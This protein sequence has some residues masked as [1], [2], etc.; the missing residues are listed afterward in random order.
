[1][2]HA[3]SSAR[4]AEAAFRADLRKFPDSGW[5]LSGLQASLERQGTSAEAAMVKA[6]FEAAWRDADTPLTAAR[7]SANAQR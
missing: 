3:G 1:M 7:P 2:A 6:R 5:S 4:E